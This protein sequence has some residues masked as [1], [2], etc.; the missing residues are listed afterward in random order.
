MR[1]PTQELYE[2]LKKD[3]VDENQPSAIPS[4]ESIKTSELSAASSFTRGPW[5]VRAATFCD[6][7]IPSYEVVMPGKPCMNALDAR[8]IGKAPALYEALRLLVIDLQDYEAWQ[9]PCHALVDVAR[10]ALDLS[11]KPDSS[12]QKG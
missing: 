6:D 2:S 4:S 12:E 10:A 5:K 3:Q 8:L 1:N 9:R 7:G 11:Y